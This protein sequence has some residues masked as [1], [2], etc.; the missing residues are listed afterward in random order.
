MRCVY[1]YHY[2]ALLDTQAVTS[3][4]S[5]A[6]SERNIPNTSIEVDWVSYNPGSESADEFQRLLKHIP[7]SPE[8]IICFEKIY[9]KT[10]LLY[11]IL[12]VVKCFNVPYVVLGEQNV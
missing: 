7:M 6:L 10:D 9:N 1:Y 8:D 12:Q 5:F 11:R 3:R 2:N 4:I